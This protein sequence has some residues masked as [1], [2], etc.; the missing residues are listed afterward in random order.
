MTE[1]RWP[2]RT[3]TGSGE[4]RRFPGVLMRPAKCFFTGTLGTRRELGANE[5]AARE[6]DGQFKIDQSRGKIKGFVS[7]RPRLIEN[8]DDL[9]EFVFCINDCN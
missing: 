9:H 6:N 5:W 7:G 8:G 2:L 1:A 3:A 4:G